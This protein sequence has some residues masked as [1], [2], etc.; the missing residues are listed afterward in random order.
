M[1]SNNQR[2]VF[3]PNESLGLLST[4]SYYN[5]LTF[6]D[7]C[8]VKTLFQGPLCVYIQDDGYRLGEVCGLAYCHLGLAM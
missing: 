4:N 1:E 3:A 5:N 6:L 8:L 2:N 7:Y